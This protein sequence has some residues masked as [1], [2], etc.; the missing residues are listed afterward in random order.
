MG[1]KDKSS[2]LE[3]L[4]LVTQ[5]G[6]SMA[7]PIVAGIFLGNFLDNKL[8][9]NVIFLAIFSILGVITSFLNLYKLT[10]RQTKGK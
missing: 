6:I 8:G 2:I 10:K 9:T 1:K 3:N 7:L 5:I 4:A